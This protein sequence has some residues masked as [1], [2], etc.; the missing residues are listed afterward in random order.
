[1]LTISVSSSRVTITFPSV[2]TGC[3]KWMLYSGLLSSVG[4]LLQDIDTIVKIRLSRPSV[5]LFRLLDIFLNFCISFSACSSYFFLSSSTWRALFSLR[6]LKKEHK[7]QLLQRAKQTKQLS[8]SLRLC[9]F[10]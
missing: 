3:G 4:K 10:A 9:S 5:K 1:M 6:T 8:H 2:S 7:P